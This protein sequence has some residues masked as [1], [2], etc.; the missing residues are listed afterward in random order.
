MLLVLRALRRMVLQPLPGASAAGRLSHQLSI[1]NYINFCN[2]SSEHIMLASSR[3][4][5]LMC[6]IVPG[7]CLRESVAA[8]SS[9]VY[10]QSAGAGVLAYSV[11]QLTETQPCSALC[12]RQLAVLA[13]PSRFMTVTTYACHNSNLIHR[14]RRCSEDPAT[15]RASI[16]WKRQHRLAQR[17]FPS[18][19]VCGVPR[20][21][22][23][24][25]R[26]TS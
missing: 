19:S 26:P 6:C 14:S 2:S 12:D 16:Y 7:V 25:Q 9:F 5:Y 17:F 22:V 4:K 1:I 18:R 11:S 13:C 10:I 21:R 3:K 8:R 15:G 20:W 23:Q 24:Y